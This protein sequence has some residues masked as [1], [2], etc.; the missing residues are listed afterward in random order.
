MTDTEHPIC[1]TQRPEEPADAAYLDVCTGKGT[2]TACSIA[3]PP[4]CAGH[5]ICDACLALAIERGLVRSGRLHERLRLWHGGAPGLHPGDLI[6][7]RPDGD[8]THLV[9][10]CPICEARRTTGQIED[11]GPQQDRVYVTTDRGYAR[12]YAASYPH[13]ALYRVEAVGDLEETTGAEDPS[14]AVPAARVLAVYD[15]R[16]TLTTSET[17]RFVGMATRR[18]P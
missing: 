9:D 14:W 6:E 2:Q 1:V 5:P 16:V 18:L 12:L 10:G 3:C 11:H 8:D 7:P 4:E 17:Q 15:A 13:G